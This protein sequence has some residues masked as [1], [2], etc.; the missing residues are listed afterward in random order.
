MA[1]P[2]VL[3]GLSKKNLVSHMVAPLAAINSLILLF[4]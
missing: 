4:G 1:M 2:V 3:P